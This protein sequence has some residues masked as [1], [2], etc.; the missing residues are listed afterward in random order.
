MLLA[1]SYLGDMGVTSRVIRLM[2][3]LSP[4]DLTEAGAARVRGMLA[5]QRLVLVGLM[6][7]LLVFVFAVEGPSISFAVPAALLVAMWTLV[8]VRLSPRRLARV[9]VAG[10]LR[11]NAWLAG[12]ITVELSPAGLRVQTATTDSSISWQHYPFRLDTDRF[13]LLLTG[14]GRFG[15]M[16]ILPLAAVGPA[17][18]QALRAL[19]AQ[20]TQPVPQGRAARSR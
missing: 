4:D 9:N 5:R 7:V 16:Q 18:Q 17:D 1:M 19:V 20:T 11:D 12:P 14:S 2:F 8:L 10:Q 3:V 13:I 15:Q 6:L